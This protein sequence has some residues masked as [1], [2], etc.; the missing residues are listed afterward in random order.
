MSKTRST[1]TKVATHKH[2]GP[3]MQPVL[4]ECKK[5]TPSWKRTLHHFGQKNVRK[6][7]FGSQTYLKN[8]LFPTMV[9]FVWFFDIISEIWMI[10]LKQFFFFLSHIWTV[11]TDK[12][13]WV[14]I[15]YT[16]ML[17]Y[18]GMIAY[19]NLHI[20]WNK[21]IFVSNFH[22]DLEDGFFFESRSPRWST[23]FI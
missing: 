18:T 5:K 21:A 9:P 4:P 8:G 12:R 1:G 6:R 7:P 13:L 22:V 16:Y 19:Q 23:W 17:Y 11:K 14:L 3:R 15:L 10:I 2:Q 20:G